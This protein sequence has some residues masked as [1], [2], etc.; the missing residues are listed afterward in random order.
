MLYPF[1]GWRVSPVIASEVRQY[2]GLAWIFRMTPVKNRI[3]TP[4]VPLVAQL[5][6]SYTL[7]IYQASGRCEIANGY[8][9]GYRSN[10]ANYHDQGKF[11]VG[12]F[13]PVFSVFFCFLLI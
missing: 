11:Q 3:L 1:F 4:T 10:E 5:E 6:N 8:A 9:Q 13:G 2:R 12:S 7:H